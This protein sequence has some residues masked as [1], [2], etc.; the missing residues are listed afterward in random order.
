MLNKMKVIPWR[1]RVVR[2]LN[3]LFV[4]SE[5]NVSTERVKRSRATDINMGS[6]VGLKNPDKIGTF[7][8]LGKEREKLI[9]TFILSCYT[10]Y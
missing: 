2:K 5:F 3:Y 9:S 1:V 6:V 10:L 7:C 4:S 8:L